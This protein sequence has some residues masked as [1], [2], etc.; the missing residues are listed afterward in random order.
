MTHPPDL[1]FDAATL[2]APVRARL[3]DPAATVVGAGTVAC[4]SAQ[5]QR[6][7]YRVAGTAHTASGVQP[8][9]LILKVIRPPTGDA[10]WSPAAWCYWEREARIYQSGILADLPGG[11]RAVR[12]YGAVQQPDGAHWLWLEACEPFAVPWPLARYA[13]AAAHFGVFNGAY[14]ADRPLP[15]A[16]WLGPG[17][18]ASRL[19]DLDARIAA[20][21]PYWELPLVQRAFPAPVAAQCAAL[22]ARRG[23]WLALLAQLPQTF[24]HLDTWRGNLFAGTD[25][26]GSPVTIALDWALCGYAPAGEEIAALVWVTLLEFLLPPDQA[27]ALEAAVLAHYLAGLRSRG[28]AG[29]VQ[30]VRFAYLA[31]A[32]L[33]WATLPEAVLFA[34]DAT[35]GAWAEAHWGRPLAEIVAQS[36]VVT[37]ALL[38][39]VDEAERLFAALTAPR[40]C[41]AQPPAVGW[42]RR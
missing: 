39:W 14:L 25:P 26:T 4:L 11:L 21:A 27:D 19:A 28:W 13:E 42:P 8:W 10:A 34:G 3:A 29:D 12:C 33:Q 36:A 32:L 40:S 24:C 1:V 2:T 5:G 18:L 17:M 30:A 7:V 22:A 41:A 6:T 31:H 16:P 38:A 20:A 15:Q 37:S 23:P 9:V 35:A